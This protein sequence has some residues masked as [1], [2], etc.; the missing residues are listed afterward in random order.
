LAT[1]GAVLRFIGRSAKRVAITVVGFVLILAGLAL[2]LPGIPGPGIL[3]I[4]AGLAVL[5][6]EYAWAR[7]V[8]DRARDQARRATER[9]RRARRRGS[10]PPET[11]EAGS[12]P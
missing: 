7:R 8:L 9:I 1:I 4:I 2:S 12:G 5:A 3:V 10:S 6:T 11:D